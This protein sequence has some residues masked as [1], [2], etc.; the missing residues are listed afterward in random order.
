MEKRLI[1]STRRISPSRLASSDGRQHA[2]IL[3]ESVAWAL[4][5]KS[6]NRFLNQT[7]NRVF[8]GRSP[9]YGG[10]STLIGIGKRFVH[11]T[12]RISPNRFA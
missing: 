12:R 8:R 11:L 4:P 6:D 1:H 5:A 9:R 10:R 3:R 2:V 7:I